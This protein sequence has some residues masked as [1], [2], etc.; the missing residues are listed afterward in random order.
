MKLE[1]LTWGIEALDILLRSALTPGSSILLAGNP[2]T[3]K[4]TLAA[5]I[6]YKNALIG[7]PCLYTTFQEEKERFINQM[8]KFGMDFEQLEK[9]GLFR[10]FRLPLVSD[11]GM[12]SDIIA[13]I[14]EIAEKQG[15]KVVVIDSF[16]PLGKAVNSD[17][18]AR[19]LLQNFFY[20]LARAINGI[21]VLIAEVPLGQETIALGDI[22]FVTDTV[23][24][25]K[26]RIAKG[27]IVRT[28][29]I[30]KARGAPLALV[31]MPFSIV[32]RRGIVVHVPPLINELK[33]PKMEVKIK[34]PCKALAE[35]IDHLHPGHYVYMVVPPD[36]RSYNYLMLLTLASILLNKLRT[37]I[38]S[39]QW[40]PEEYIEILKGFGKHVLKHSANSYSNTI[41]KIRHLITIESLNPAAMSLEEL[42]SRELTKVEECKP[43][44]V[45]FDRVDIVSTIHGIKDYEKYFAYLR[46][47]LLYFRQL[48]I[49]TVRVSALVDGDTYRREASIADVVLRL[50][51]QRENNTLRPYLYVWRCGREPKIIGPE[52]LYECLIEARSLFSG[53]ED[54]GT[55]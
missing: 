26:H 11:E 4:T 54:E 38:V 32:D 18:R 37:L 53:V 15:A 42:Y 47:E 27:M 29:E 52:T 31:E 21:V 55:N 30:R 36:A 16:T 12:V 45:I 6:C 8:K 20:N 51:H 33:P 9:Q 24:I 2:G 43:Q 46:N 22:E 49:L 19:T 10:F 28:L 23:I 17:I 5:T 7:K 40:S 34:L 3:G 25:L 44:A 14:T 39:Y 50:W 35:A 41:N 1:T 48:G 13:S